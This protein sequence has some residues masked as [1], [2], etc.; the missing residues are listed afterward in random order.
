MKMKRNVNKYFEMI[1]NFFMLNII[2]IG[3]ILLSNLIFSISTKFISNQYFLSVLQLFLQFLAVLCCIAF[4]YK[5]ILK[6]KFFINKKLHRNVVFIVV[7]ALICALINILLICITKTITFDGFISKVYYMEDIIPMLLVGLIEVGSECI[8][9][10]LL[11][12][13]VSIDFFSKYINLKLSIIITSIYYIIVHCF[14]SQLTIF[15]II[16]LILINILMSLI[17]VK[18]QNIWYCILPRFVFEFITAYGFSMNR[19]GRDEVGIVFLSRVSNSYLNGGQYGIY[20]S[21]ITMILLIIFIV[22]F[23][24]FKMKE[25]NINKA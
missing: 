12:R 18:Y 15:S 4:F 2:A 14:D 7:C 8:Y 11:F 20:G 25:I 3:F 21:A 6:E 16:N 1:V 10:E 17:Y 13:K 9:E 24:I 22:L 19:F 5:I 23:I